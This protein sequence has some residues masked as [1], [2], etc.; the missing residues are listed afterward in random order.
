MTIE[1]TVVSTAFGILSKY[2]SMTIAELHQA[3]DAAGSAY[4]E[5]TGSALF[6]DD[7]VDTEHGRM[8]P[9]LHEAIKSA[10]LALER[11]VPETVEDLLA[12]RIDR[13]TLVGAPIFDAGLAPNA[14]K[15][16]RRA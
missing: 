13:A 8:S 1:N 10:W 16:A 12:Q 5:R 6:R 2:G 7:F 14:G 11:P 15:A 3:V 9:T 4:R